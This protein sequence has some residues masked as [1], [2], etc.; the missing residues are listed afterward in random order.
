MLDIY[1]TYGDLGLSTTEL[2]YVSSLFTIRYGSL[3]NDSSKKQFGNIPTQEKNNPSLSWSLGA[4]SR[5]SVVLGLARSSRL[6]RK[7]VSLLAIP[8]RPVP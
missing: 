1:S 3:R 8:A 7:P 2:F 5:R 6:S 4:Y